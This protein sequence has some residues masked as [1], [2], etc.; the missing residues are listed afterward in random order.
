MEADPLNESVRG[1]EKLWSEETM[2]MDLFT[3]C[4]CGLFDAVRQLAQGALKG[5]GAGSTSMSSLTATRNLEGWTPLMYASYT[6]HDM[7]VN[8]LLEDMEADPNV[9]GVGGKSPLMCA[10]AAGNESVAYFLINHGADVSATDSTVSMKWL[11]GD[12]RAVLV[13]SCWVPYP[14][15]L[16]IR[17][18]GNDGSFLRS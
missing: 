7:V 9:C 2:P 12:A 3:A 18:S 11:G 16:T 5:H 10:S 8:F 4:A 6:G 17:S 15:L 1:L 13:M 14:S